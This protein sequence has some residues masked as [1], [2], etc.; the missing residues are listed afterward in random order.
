MLKK[1]IYTGYHK[2]INQKTGKIKL[3]KHY[4]NGV[5]H[6]KIIYYWDNGKIRL[7]GQYHNM[8]RIGLWQMFDANGNMIMKENYFPSKKHN[9]N[10]KRQLAI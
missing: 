3:L 2:L 7:T 4:K 8:Q 6:G 10:N 1:N 9:L 5:L